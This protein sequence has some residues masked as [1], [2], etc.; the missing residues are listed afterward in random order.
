ML[1]D[2]SLVERGLAAHG[3]PLADRHPDVKEMAKGQTLRVRLADDGM[4]DDVERIGET[5]NGAVW[6]LRDGQHNGFPGLKT[7]AGLLPLDGQARKTHEQAWS[8]DK[9]P[10]ARR[11]ELERLVAASG[12]PLLQN[13]AW[14]KPGHRKRIAERLEQLRPL[15]ADP[16]AASVPACMERFLQ[17]LPAFLPNLAEA[18]F[19]K[20]ADGDDG[21]L[22]I[23]QAALTGPVPLVIDVAMDDFTL[24]ASHPQQIAAVSA[25]LSRPAGTNG[26]DAAPSGFCALSGR[27]TA[28]HRGN[29]PQPN[30]PA[31]G[32]SYIFARNGDIPS[33]ARYGR[34]G[35]ASF[36][37]AADLAPRLNAVFGVLTA[38]DAKGQTWRLIPPE[39]G[40]KS[41]LLIV[42][43]PAVA[44][45]PVA[46]TLA[47][48]SREEDVDEETDGADTIGGMDLLRELASRVIA[49]SHGEDRHDH[50]ESGMTVLILRAV[51]PANRKA[52]YHRQTDAQALFDAAER[53]KAATANVPD[54]IVFP[55]PV[56]G[57]RVPVPRGPS[58]V[59]PLS[60]TRLSRMQFVNGGRR[61]L[62][63][64]GTPAGDAFELF[65]GNGAVKRRARTLLRLL[66]RRHAALLGGLAAA[67]S[68]GID[69]L[70]DFDPKADLRRDALRS[71]TWIGVLLHQLSRPKEDYMASTAASTAFRLGQLLA[72]A[73]TLHIGYCADLRSGD[74]PPSLIGNAVLTIAGNRPQRALAILQSRLKPYLA[75]ARREEYLEKRTRELWVEKPASEAQKLSEAQKK[76]LRLYWAIRKGAASAPRLTG[77]V[78]DLLK[79]DLG[80]RPD[81]EFKAEL[82]L[83]YLAGLPRPAG[84]KP[85][86][87]NDNT[88]TDP[89]GETT[90]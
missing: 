62:S 28:L 25:A 82:L 21:W 61:R 19:K 10:A 81:D 79:E 87:S 12:P 63:V 31:L 40:D 50:A 22:D 51:D 23:V 26:D 8:A 36:P 60:I 45:E 48:D 88:E 80:K 20:L 77:L 89:N 76:S 38:P 4:I 34:A 66:L 18:L 75:W 17:G 65:L 14:P 7:D 73:D 32:Q 86:T 3:V 53:W 69:H 46:D 90:S 5:G 47:G 58:Y 84:E 6:T 41:D 24:D 1:N 78:G 64:A 83:G 54:G 68:K 37:L 85:G 16:L 27:K 44:G 33:L 11:R 13:E 55:V 74:V 35:S 59:A 72:G 52:I 70:K 56:K 29:F 71:V 67:R 39:T 30:L 2:L 57:R 43:L 9:S 15:A 42:S 49:H